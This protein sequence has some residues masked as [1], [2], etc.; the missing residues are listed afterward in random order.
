MMYDL[1]KTD[2]NPLSYVHDMVALGR[3]C[4]IVPENDFILQ[5]IA[6]EMTD[7]IRA[8][9]QGADIAF[10]FLER[11]RRHVIASALAKLGAPKTPGE[12]ERFLAA[13]L[14]L[15]NDAL[16]RWA[17]GDC[18]KG[19]VALLRKLDE[20]LLPSDLYEKAYNFVCRHPDSID[21]V[22]GAVPTRGLGRDQVELLLRLPSMGSQ[23]VKVWTKFE[24]TRAYDRFME[25]YRA[26]TGLTEVSPQHLE[27]LVG[28]EDP[29]TLVESVYLDVPFPP[30]VITGLPNI[31]YIANARQLRM[32]AKQF[33][34]CLTN[35]TE[36]ALHGEKQFYIVTIDPKMKIIL[37]IESDHPFA[38]RFFDIKG[39]RN[40]EPDEAVVKE[41]KAL[42]GT[43]GIYD[44]PDTDTLVRR[45]KRDSRFPDELERALF[46]FE[47]P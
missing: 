22:L 29:S 8:A 37:G 30:P 13:F 36:S 46:G 2:E 39:P 41:L 26:V 10:A 19:Y 18:P 31:T 34:N 33:R 6:G 23:L 7:T 20:E 4:Q 3:K 47:D 5:R 15:K 35:F 44:R 42:L 16:I 12:A 45:L 24:T 28:G 25:A 38:F 11:G 27:R 1:R 17:Y 32:V 14:S 21:P 40:A 9:Y 43:F